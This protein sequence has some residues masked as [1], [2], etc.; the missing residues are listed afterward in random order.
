MK[1]IKIKE[2]KIYALMLETKFDE[3][4]YIIAFIGYISWIITAIANL[5]IRII[6]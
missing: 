6:G 1:F 2:H 5:I 4:I 3:I